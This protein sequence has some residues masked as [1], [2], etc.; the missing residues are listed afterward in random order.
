MRSSSR[1]GGL[2]SAPTA[3]P[4]KP[5]ASHLT[6]PPKCCA[7]SWSGVEESGGEA[8][9]RSSDWLLDGFCQSGPDGPAGGEV[10]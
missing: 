8:V 7:V 10:D 4:S 2:L 5:Q 3:R 6:P 9:E 1:A